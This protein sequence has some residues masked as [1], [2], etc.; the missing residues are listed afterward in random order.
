MTEF[1][2]PGNP[3]IFPFLTLS[4]PHQ[5]HTD[6]FNFLDAQLQQCGRL[7]AGLSICKT[8]KVLTLQLFDH[9][10]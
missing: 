6:D 5:K 2:H 4:N 3:D 9:K 10:A 8:Q 1:S 7:R